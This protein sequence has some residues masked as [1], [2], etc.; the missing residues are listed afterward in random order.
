MNTHLKTP[1]KILTLTAAL[2]CLAITSARG[3]SG[4]H[5]WAYSNWLLGYDLGFIKRGLPGTLIYFLTKHIPDSTATTLQLIE[6][7]SGFIFLVMAAL[8]LLIGFK[9]IHQQRQEPVLTVFLIAYCVSPAISM[10][11]NL[12]GYYDQ[13]ITIITITSLLLCMRNL[14]CTA[15]AISAIAV[16]IHESIITNTLP[17]LVL[18]NICQ[19]NKN[20]NL[21]RR[22]FWLNLLKLS[23]PPLIAF[24]AILIN[25]QLINTTELSNKIIEILMH[26]MTQNTERA[27]FYAEMLT[28]SFTEYI[29]TE[30]EKFPDR[31]T[32]IN[33]T[34]SILPFIIASTALTWHQTKNKT[35]R[36]TLFVFFTLAS[37]A[38]LSL[39]LIA[40]DTERIWTMPITSTFI[41]IWILSSTGQLEIKHDNTEKFL[42]QFF[43]ALTIYY[44][45]LRPYSMMPPAINL[46]TSD[47]VILYGIPVLYLCWLTSQ[48][49][50]DNADARNLCK[51]QTS[52]S[53]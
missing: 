24:V 50:H 28:H 10:T 12:I 46:V 48:H 53:H 3:I 45:S 33:Y 40:F 15:G 34:T 8:L 18:W 47:L 7:I 52:Q 6:I 35:N 41:S 25:Q 17:L 27:H 29:A 32:D 2:I 30:S 23:G 9:T 26:N 16:F 37:I 1:E 20:D 42:T 43:L 31:I 13:I 36:L 19:S 5:E 39:H 21:W 22:T 38:P 14:L 44:I 49:H 4:I 11:G 51:K